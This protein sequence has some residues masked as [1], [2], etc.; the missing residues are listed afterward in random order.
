MLFFFSKSVNENKTFIGIVVAVL[1]TIW[2]FF[3]YKSSTS[4][5]NI[6]LRKPVVSNP[7]TA[8]HSVNLFFSPWSKQYFC[9][10][11]SYK[12]LFSVN[13]MFCMYKCRGI[14]AKDQHYFALRCMLSQYPLKQICSNQIQLQSFSIYFCKVLEF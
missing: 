10:K 4:A 7:C 12:E 5:V 11:I 2:F 14:Y 8:V 9:F 1:P 3:S 13:F 6:L